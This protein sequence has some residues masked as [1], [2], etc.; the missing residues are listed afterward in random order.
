MQKEVERLDPKALVW[1]G[2][3]ATRWVNAFH[4]SMPVSSK[5]D[6]ESVWTVPVE[7]N[8]QLKLLGNSARV[9][10]V[11]AALRRDFGPTKAA[12]ASHRGI[13]PLLQL[14]SSRPEQKTFRGWS[15]IVPTGELGRAPEV[16][17]CFC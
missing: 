12:R 15:C 7:D 6:F 14:V 9:I 16:S 2:F 1:S 8:P 13:K 4:L 10:V 11:G 3:A 5:G 17:G